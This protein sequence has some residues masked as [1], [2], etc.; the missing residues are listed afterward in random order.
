MPS[1]STCILKLHWHSNICVYFTDNGQQQQVAHEFKFPAF[2]TNELIQMVDEIFDT[3]SDTLNVNCKQA[4][5]ETSVQTDIVW[6]KI[7]DLLKQ[8]AATI[9]RPISDTVENNFAGIYAETAEPQ[10]DIFLPSNSEKIHG[11]PGIIYLNA[12]ASTSNVYCRHTQMRQFK[13]CSCLKCKTDIRFSG[14]HINPSPKVM[15]SRSS[16][17]SSSSSSAV[18][19]SRPKPSGKIKLFPSERYKQMKQAQREHFE[20]DPRISKTLKKIYA[21]AKTLK[22]RHETTSSSSG[23]FQLSGRQLRSSFDDD[24]LQP[25]LY[26]FSDELLLFGLCSSDE[27]QYSSHLLKT[28]SSQDTFESNDRHCRMDA[29]SKEILFRNKLMCTDSED[30]SCNF[31]FDKRESDL[32]RFLLKDIENSGSDPAMLSSVFSTSSLEQKV[33][34]IQLNEKIKCN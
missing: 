8:Q 13:V 27:V 34:E 18:Y 29:R 32:E 21:T 22:A 6:E 28:E 4:V 12:G 19:S 9:K 20:N 16:S 15:S 24:V 17:T 31:F 33:N 1:L 11:R 23:H 25:D 26:T 3:S 2:P 5:K 14:M 30:S 7:N 10:T